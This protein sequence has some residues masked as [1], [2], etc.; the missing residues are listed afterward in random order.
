MKVLLTGCSSGIGLGMLENLLSNGH[1]VIGI[2]RDFTKLKKEI[3]TNSNF[4]PLTFDL[5]RTTEIIN[6]FNDSFIE[7]SKFDA[8]IHCAGVEETLPLTVYTPEK[9]HSVFNINVFAA[10][11]LT[12]NFSKKKFSNEGASIVFL[13][14]VMGILGQPGKV[15]YCSSKS[16]IL[17]V[18]KSSALEL[19]KRRIRVNAILPGVV[20]TPMTQKLFSQLEKENIDKILNMH[21]LGI[22]KVEDVVEMIYFLIS[23]QSRWITGQNF[24]VDGGYSIQ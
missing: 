22:G 14:S 5:S 8:L 24:I 10:V 13:S 2:A 9:I 4:V 7:D 16:A 1:T 6:I 20:D 18:V 17:G 11:E 15:G 3:F 23:E 19:S 21:P 12:R